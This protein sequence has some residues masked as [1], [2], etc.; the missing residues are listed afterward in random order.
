[1]KKLALLFCAIMLL[2]ALAL[3]TY[4]QESEGYELLKNGD[5]EEVTLDWEKYY[6]ATVDY[7]TEAHSG[8]GAFSITRREHS[9]DIARQYITKPLSYYGHGQ[10]D[11]SAWVRLADA[12][13]EPIEMQIALGLYSKSGAQHWVTT[14]WVTVTQEWTHISARVY[15]AWHD[16]LETAEFYLVTP[17]N[18]NEDTTKNFRNLILDDCSM[19]AASF[20][21]EP[22]APPT[23]AAPT[24]EPET[25]PPATEAPTTDAPATEAPT[26]ETPIT[27]A[28]TAEPEE[29]T[30]DIEQQSGSIG[31]QTLIITCTMIA[32]GIILLGCAI[33][34]T[35]S[36]IRG[37]RNEANK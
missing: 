4:A 37:K 34:L 2:G 5:F 29:Q 3:P 24:T 20:T 32:V 22:Y 25:E 14:Q 30:T 8:N 23:T 18:G 12:D 28:P 1:M 27:E 35:V 33:A 6:K 10:Y 13:A 11:L 15:V 9:T 7:T 16:E 19:K 17:M 26:T 31:T 21:G 36:Y